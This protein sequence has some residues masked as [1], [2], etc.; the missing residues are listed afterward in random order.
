MRD[1]ARNE[2]ARID[3]AQGVSQPKEAVAQFQAASPDGSRVF[4][5]DTRRLLPEASTEP[6]GELQGE[7]DL[8]ECELVEREHR[9]A[10]NLRDLTPHKKS[11]TV[12]VQGAVPGV[13]E[14]A[15]EDGGL[16]IYFV[17]NGVLA[18]GAARPGRLSESGSNR[19]VGRDMQP[20]RRALRPQQM[21]SAEV[22]RCP[23]RG[24]RAGMGLD[25]ACA[26]QTSLKSA[27]ACRP[28]ATPRVHVRPRLTGYN[29]EDA[30]HPGVQDEE[31]FLYNGKTGLL[32][33]ASCNPSGARPAGVLDAGSANGFTGL[34]ADQSQ[35]WEL[36]APHPGHE[37]DHWLAGSVPAWTGRSPADAEYQSR[38][39][40]NSGRLYFNSPDRLVPADQN[41]LE[42]VYQF[43]QNGVGLVREHE[44]L[45]RADLRRRR[46]SHQGIGV[47]RRE[48][49]RQRRLHPHG[50][51]ARKPGPRRGPRHLRRARVLAVLLGPPPPPPPPCE[52]EGC[53][54][55]PTEVP[56]MPPV[57]PSTAPGPGNHGTVQVLPFSESK[58][59]VT[60]KTETRAQK[61][62][63][64][65]KAC[66][67][68][69]NR[70]K[71]QTCEHTARKKYG[72]PT[73]K[74]TRK[75]KGK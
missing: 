60:H 43:E 65:L 72:P 55:P 39:L 56:A 20:V 62:A 14:E 23:Q 34:L 4:F 61:L 58:P 50:E 47:P 35:S 67:T 26:E 75:G 8:Y 59:P 45:R 28:T 18:P 31:V 2:T 29:N 33:C 25:G 74:T 5:T 54:P 40:S 51:P 15:S 70:L 7:G 30:N 63:K 12:A 32:S 21:G 9:L 22:H 27:R 44:R 10:C 73:K 48:R 66:K 53:K 37:V 71:R 13:S 49:H 6:E 36:E 64:A 41:Q 68:K 46:R 19:L 17:A 69:R 11:E 3:L 24:R 1:F 16:Y 57:P 42:D 38:Y 52:G